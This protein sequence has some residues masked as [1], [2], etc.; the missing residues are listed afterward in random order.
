VHKLGKILFVDDDPNVLSGLERSMGH[1]KS[2]WDI[3]LETTPSNAL[4]TIRERQID[5]MVTDIAMPEMT[6]LEL[7][8]EVN[9]LSPK[10]KCI[11]LTGSTEFSLVCR[12]VNDLNI[13]KYYVKPAPTLDLIK[14]I[15]NIH[16]DKREISSICFDKILDEMS[17]GVM[18]LSNNAKVSYMNQRAADLIILD[19]GLKISSDGTLRGISPDKSAAILCKYKAASSVDNDELGALSLERPSSRAPLR[20]YFSNLQTMENE[21]SPQ[22]LLFIVDPVHQMLPSAK[23]L[24]AYFCFTRTESVFAWHVMH[25]DRLEDIADIMGITYSS[26]RTYMKRVMERAGTTRQVDLVRLLLL[27]PTAYQ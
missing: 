5:V 4:E 16:I 17:F 22:V 20:L 19:D 2:Q 10:T 7:I 13:D 27:V 26:A 6:G 21:Q 1:I 24:S 9:N 3:T 23:A 12:A 14:Y 8:A 11:I 15:S 18:V 25:G